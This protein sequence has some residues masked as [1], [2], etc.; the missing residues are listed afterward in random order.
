M[1]SIL[2]PWSC[3]PTTELTSAS[4]WSAAIQSISLLPQPTMKPSFS[5]PSPYS[6]SFPR[7]REECA[8]SLTFGPILSARKM[9]IYCILLAT[10]ASPR[11][12]TTFAES[13]LRGRVVFP[14]SRCWG[15]ILPF[16]ATISALSRLPSL[17]SVSLP[18]RPWRRSR[19]QEG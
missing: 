13:G 16:L 9:H 1:C 2:F 5:P 12:L 8:T 3:T 4:G 18:S 17:L 10:T 19:E 11:L 14:H 7:S 15:S 6:R